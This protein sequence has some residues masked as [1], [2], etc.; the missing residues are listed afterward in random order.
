M[1]RDPVYSGA[2]IFNSSQ[3]GGTEIVVA[4]PAIIEKTEFE[5]AQR[6]LTDR[7]PRKTAPRVVAGPILLTGLAKCPH[8]ESAMTMRTGKRGAYKYY[9]CSNKMRTGVTSCKGRSVPMSDLDALIIQTVEKELGS[10]GAVKEIIAPLT[11]RRNQSLKKLDEILNERETEVISTKRVLDNIYQLVQ[12]GLVDASNPDFKKRFSLAKA[13]FEK[14]CAQR[15]QVTA[16]LA[17]E[18]KVDHTKISDFVD[19][20]TEA[21]Q[22]DA[23]PTKKGYLRTLI[24]EIVVGEECITIS[25]QRSNFENAIKKGRLAPSW[26]PTFVREWRRRWDSNPRYALTHAGFQDRCIR[27]LCHSSA[28]QTA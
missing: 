18:D 8:C 24:N 6:I 9:A 2:S 13:N 15:D 7:N 26:V 4:V 19:A 28:A 27:P 21:L 20:L 23:I 5:A 25:G 1:L 17:P 12:E 11:D 14:A 3:N 16:E 22:G 10:V